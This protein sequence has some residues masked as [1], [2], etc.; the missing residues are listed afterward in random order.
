VSVNPFNLASRSW[1]AQLSGVPRAAYADT[2]SDEERLK[3]AGK[4]QVSLA[5]AVNTVFQVTGMVTYDFFV[6]ARFPKFLG[7][8]A[9]W[10]VLRPER[11][12]ERSESGESSTIMEDA[13]LL[14]SA[15]FS[16]DGPFGVPAT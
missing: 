12:G 3:Q 15:A 11:A 13:L 1:F 16:L 6:F 8:F 5:E 7:G 9:H 2:I 4:Q 14:L 10:G